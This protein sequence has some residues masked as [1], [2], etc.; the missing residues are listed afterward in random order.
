M[1]FELSIMSF[2]RKYR[3]QTISE[4]DSVEMSARLAKAFSAESIPHA[5]LFAG[6]KGTGKTS[7]ARIIAKLVN[8]TRKKKSTLNGI[9]YFEPCNTCDSCLSITRGSHMDVLEIDAAS[10]RGIDEI[11]DL[12]EKIR[13]SPGQSPYKVYIIDEVH[14][15]TTEAFNALLKT[16]EEPPAHAI[17]ILATTESDK[18]PGT[19]LSR[20][21]LFKF[22]K[23]GKEDIMRSL[24]RVVGGEKIKIPEDVLAQ[25]A[26]VADGSFRDATKLLEQALSEGATTLSSFQ[27]IFGK[28]S[29]DSASVVLLLSKKDTKALL[30]ILEDLDRR[31]GDARI[32]VAELLNFLHRFLLVY[33]GVY[34]DPGILK[35][36]NILSVSDILTLIKLFSAS[37]SMIKNSSSSV[38]PVTVAVVEWCEK[39]SEKVKV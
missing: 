26:E 30:T 9:T 14:M 17:F 1:S 39:K 22:Q 24:N 21:M 37:F 35:M 18:L 11:R 10:N 36:K 4:L 27:K 6:P 15:L 23:A 7:A 12:R 31:G 20:T 33:Y 8:C 3:P 32:F 38:L 16:L 25:I 5:L 19:I 29:S 13:L 2:Y 28:S 34:D